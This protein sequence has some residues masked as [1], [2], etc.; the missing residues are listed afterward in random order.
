MSSATFTGWTLSEAFEKIVPDEFFQALRDADANADRATSFAGT[1]RMHEGSTKDGEVLR[2]LRT[3]ELNLQKAKQDIYSRFRYSARRG[4]VVVIGVASNSDYS[5]WIPPQV[6]TELDGFLENRSAVGRRPHDNPDALLPDGAFLSVS[7]FPVL[8]APVEFTVECLS[9]ELLS[10]VIDRFVWGDPETFKIWNDVLK[11]SDR[12]PNGIP[13][14]AS[15]RGVLLALQQDAKKMRREIDRVGLARKLGLDDTEVDS[16]T[17][18]YLDVLADR[19]AALGE[20]IAT[21]RIGLLGFDE[22]LSERI[23]VHPVDIEA[24]RLLLCIGTGDLYRVGK[25]GGAIRDVRIVEPV[26]HGV[27]VVAAE[28]G[29]A[30]NSVTDDEGDE[31]NGDEIEPGEIDRDKSKGGSGGKFDWRS[32]IRSAIITTPQGGRAPRF[33]SPRRFQE[34]VLDEIK[35]RNLPLPAGDENAQLNAVGKTIKKLYPKLYEAI[36][37]PI[38]E[39]PRPTKPK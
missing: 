35:R 10:T 16:T 6:W 3:T 12:L 31:V 5:S 39:N 37:A 18:R 2:A 21:D 13:E 4:D 25:S 29:S 1:V 11:R 24:G 17:G 27:A 33:A 20:L 28:T 34:A 38:T 9:D 14:I 8:R 36:G 22:D 32:V 30:S 26:V 23:T 7:I 19:L 15:A